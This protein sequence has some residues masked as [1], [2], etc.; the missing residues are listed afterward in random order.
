M[1]WDYQPYI[2]GIR[3]KNV[4]QTLNSLLSPTKSMVARGNHLRAPLRTPPCTPLHTNPCT[5]KHPSMHLR[6]PLLTPPCTPPHTSVHFRAPLCTL[7][8]TPPCTSAHP[9][10]HLCTPLCAPLCTLCTPP[11]HPSMH[12]HTS[13]CT[14]L[15]TSMQDSD[16]LIVPTTSNHIPAFKILINIKILIFFPTTSLKNLRAARIDQLADS[17]EPAKIKWSCSSFRGSTVFH[18]NYSQAWLVVISQ[19]FRFQSLLL[20]CL[21]MRMFEFVFSR[22]WSNDLNFSCFWLNS[23]CVLLLHNIMQS[24]ISHRIIFCTPSTRNCTQI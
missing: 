18:T 16:W 3:P 21:H 24:T 7:P 22:L 12:L 5:S 17:N 10:M 15:H 20:L 4:L 9:S 19:S 23:A 14:P 6:A 8:H 1:F 13:L 11:C 2:M